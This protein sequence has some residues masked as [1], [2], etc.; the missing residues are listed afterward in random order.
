GAR[1][2]PAPTETENAER[3]TIRSA[4]PPQDRRARRRPRN[5]GWQGRSFAMSAALRLAGRRPRA[6]LLHLAAIDR[7][8][9]RHFLEQSDI[10]PGAVGRLD[11]LCD[12]AGR[13][14]IQGE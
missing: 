12:L 10:Q 5:A 6:S 8:G 9:R 1:R 14:E 4:K 2:F 3:T 13:L 7:G 11:L